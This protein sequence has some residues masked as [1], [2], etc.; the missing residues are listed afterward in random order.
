MRS[1]LYVIELNDKRYVD[2]D[3]VIRML[4]AEEIEA[5]RHNQVN[6]GEVLAALRRGFVSLLSVELNDEVTF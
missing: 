4:M 5:V 3:D 2:L 6:T 1:K